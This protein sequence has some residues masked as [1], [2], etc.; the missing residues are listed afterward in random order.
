MI[1]KASDTVKEITEAPA[2]EALLARMGARERVTVEKHLALCDQEADREH[3]K[4]WRRLVGKLAELAP[5]PVRTQGSDAVMFFIPDGKYRMQVFAIEDKR[6]G[7][8]SVYLPDVIAEATKQKILRSTGHGHV[9]SKS[10]GTGADGG[11]TE[12]MVHAMDGSNGEDNKEYVKNL[13]GWNRKAMRLSF[14]TNRAQ[15]AEVEAA[16]RL[17]ALAAA[18]WKQQG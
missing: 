16:E 4:L 2:F 6:D 14:P 8:I 13:T 17:C 11:A 9:L 18:K 1:A 15:P 5:L 3:G 7:V 10:T 12:V